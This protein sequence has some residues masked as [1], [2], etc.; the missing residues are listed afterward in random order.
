[1]EEV[2]KLEKITQEFDEEFS[3][4]II[5]SKNVKEFEVYYFPF[6]VE[7]HI[8]VID[9]EEDDDEDIYEDVS[10]YIDKHITY[11]VTFNVD[12]KTIMEEE[13]K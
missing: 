3:V 5:F 11:S 8:K 12:D 1:M 13:T 4:N 10:D 7:N 6:R 9:Y 2:L